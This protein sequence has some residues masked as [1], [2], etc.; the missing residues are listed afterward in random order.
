M[1]KSLKVNGDLWYSVIPNKLILFSFPLLPKLLQSVLSLSFSSLILSSFPLPTFHLFLCLPFCLVS[2]PFFLTPLFAL[3]SLACPVFLYSP[4]YP[5][6]SLYF[7]PLLS[8]SYCS[9]SR[10]SFL[11]FSSRPHSNPFLLL[12][13]PFTHLPHSLS[14]LHI[15]CT[16]SSLS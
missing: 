8:Y 12:F 11:L 5:I 4:F 6:F 2:V 14:S 1:L 13:Y 7:V 15:S 3:L 9:L 10:Q 16:L